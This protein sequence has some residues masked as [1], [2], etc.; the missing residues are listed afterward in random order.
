MG[1]I[2]VIRTNQSIGGYGTRCSYYYK[3]QPLVIDPQGGTFQF[4]FDGSPVCNDPRL[5]PPD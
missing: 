2:Y 4:M 5:I 3:V 1:S